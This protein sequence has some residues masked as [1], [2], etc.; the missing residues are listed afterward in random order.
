MFPTNTATYPSVLAA[1][2]V[3]TMVRTAKV[4]ASFEQ[5]RAF[6]QEPAIA[7]FNPHDVAQTASNSEPI[8]GV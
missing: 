4:R 8:Q 7:P 5:R 3:V 1:N 2:G 6:A